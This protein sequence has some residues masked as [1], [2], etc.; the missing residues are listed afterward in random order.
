M[1]AGK[2]EQ[3]AKE[4]ELKLAFDPG[5]AQRILS[6]QILADATAPATCEL[7]SIYYDT[8]D[9]VLHKAGVFLRVRSTGDGYVQT[10]KA[11]QS[12]GEFLERHEWEK[13]VSTHLIDLDAA[14][15]TALAPLLTPG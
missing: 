15:G 14:E 2:Q 11:A 3:D 9:G 12:E 1:G 7:I 6:H 10:I 4:I 5:I 13:P 8:T